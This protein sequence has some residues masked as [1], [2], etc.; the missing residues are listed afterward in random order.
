MM[1]PFSQQPGIPMF[2]QNNHQQHNRP[3]SCCIVIPFGIGVPL[4]LTSWI[5]G[6]DN[7][8]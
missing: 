7:V 4:V 5:V 6:K 8:N 1:N 3:V 2:N